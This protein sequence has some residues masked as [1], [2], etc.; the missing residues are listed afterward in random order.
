MKKI[1]SLF[2]AI[3]FCVTLFGCKNEPSVMTFNFTPPAKSEKVTLLAVGDNLIHDAIY[4]QAN[5]QAGGEG[6]DFSSCYE[7]LADTISS[8]DIAI[9]NQETIIDPSKNPSTYPCFNSPPQLAEH[10]LDIGFDVFNLANNHTLDRGSDSLKNCLEFWAEKDAVTVGA[11]KN[12]DSS[13][14]VATITK[15]GIVFGFLGATETTNGLK[16]APDAESVLVLGQNEEFLEQKVKKADKL[17]DIVVV[18]IHWGV[19]YTHTP[20]A[21]QR[22]LAEKLTSWGAD[23]IIGH[24]PHVIQ[25][26]EYHTALNGNT[27]LV[28]YSLGNFISAQNRAPRMLGG[29]A[30]IELVKDFTDFSTKIESVELDGV[31]THYDTPFKNIR[32]Y[33]YDQ[34]TPELAKKH[35]VGVNDTF[36]YNYIVNTYRQVFGEFWN[37]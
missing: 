20:T 21:R 22:E 23:I 1:L 17:C 12:S 37:K 3:T 13:H 11:Y 7:N 31:I 18:N 10:M 4:K 25:P 8:A 34:Y 15:N 30:K 29:M 2:L 5:A 14:Q 32:T 35:G 27:S 26:V 28:F 9:I 16:L 36:N 33:L 19:E 24:H 6:Y